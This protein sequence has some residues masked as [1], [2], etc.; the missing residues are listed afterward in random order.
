MRRAFGSWPTDDFRLLDA[1]QRMA[2]YVAA[3]GMEGSAEVKKAQEMIS[4]SESHGEFYIDG[5]ELLPLS[6]GGNGAS[7]RLA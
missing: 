3:D 7:T 2:F 4:A 1:E 6:V 5:G